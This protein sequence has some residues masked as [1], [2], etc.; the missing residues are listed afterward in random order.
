MNLGASGDMAHLVDEAEVVADKDE[1]SIEG[2]DG[3]SQR[4]DALDVQVIRG[5]IQQQQVGTL[6][7]DHAEDQP[8]LLPLGQLPDLGGLYTELEVMSKAC[9]PCTSS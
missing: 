7:A 8:R 6:H 2:L 3:I 1:A 9:T 4:V 5:L